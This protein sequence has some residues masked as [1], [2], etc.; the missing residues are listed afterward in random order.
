M[1]GKNCW[2]WGNMTKIITEIFMNKLY[3]FQKSKTSH[4]KILLE[5]G[6]VFHVLAWAQKSNT[7]NHLINMNMHCDC[8][9]LVIA[10]S[11]LWCENMSALPLQTF[12][13]LQVYDADCIHMLI[14][15]VTYIIKRPYATIDTY[16]NTKL[17]SSNIPY[18]LLF[19]LAL[20]V[21]IPPSNC[22]RTIR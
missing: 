15:T 13:N 11:E 10:N 5:S 18:R 14:Y 21:V 4:R 6:S 9:G 1:V 20:I 2:F 12:E 16:K 17:L 22:N 8:F 3:F 7:N 19:N